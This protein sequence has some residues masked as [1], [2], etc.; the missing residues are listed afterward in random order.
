MSFAIIW[1]VLKIAQSSIEDYDET[2][3]CGNYIIIVP[4][5]NPLIVKQATNY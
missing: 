3:L 2:L 1:Q 4:L 5:T